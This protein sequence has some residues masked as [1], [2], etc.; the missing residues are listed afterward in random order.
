[1]FDTRKQSWQVQHAKDV[2]DERVFVAE[3]DVFAATRRAF[4]TA[5]DKR[6]V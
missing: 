3:D 2:V 5:T 6:E 4:Q 1:M